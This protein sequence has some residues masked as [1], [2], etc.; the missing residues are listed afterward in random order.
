M[1]GE[2]LVPNRRNKSEGREV[3][4]LRGLGAGAKL[5]E[6]MGG[7]WP[8]PPVVTPDWSPFLVDLFGIPEVHYV[9]GI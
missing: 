6:L 7:R 3:A 5:Y 2:K 4:A 1:T 8:P 9:G